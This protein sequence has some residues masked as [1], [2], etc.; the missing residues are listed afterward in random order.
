MGGSHCASRLVGRCWPS[1][2]AG[3]RSGRLAGR[4][5]P[6]GLV[7]GGLACVWGSGQCAGGPAGSRSSGLASGGLAVLWG[8]GLARWWTWRCR[9]GGL[10]A[11][12]VY[13][14]MVK[15]SMGQGFKVQKFQL[16]LVLYLSQVCLQ[17]LSK[18]PVS[19]RSRNLLCP[20]HHFGSCAIKDILIIHF[21]LIEVSE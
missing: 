4:L 1:R 2:T 10:P 19:Q 9:S 7:G 12:S 20:C 17:H 5:R 21:L 11:L 3:H 16:S 14:G 18:V 13:C 6:V 8:R 15:S